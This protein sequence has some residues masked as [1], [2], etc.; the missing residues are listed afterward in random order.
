MT[1]GDGVIDPVLVIRAIRRHRAHLAVDLVKQGAELGGIV[2][3]LGCQRRGDDFAGLGI[4]AK[5]QLSP[6]FAPLCAVLL[7][8]PFAWP[9]QLQPGAVDQ[10]LQRPRPRPGGRRHPQRRGPPAQGG[11]VGHRQ[12]QPHQRQERAD[13][14]L[15]L[16]QR[17]AEHRAQR[18]GG[19]NRQGRI[20]RLPARRGPRCSPP[21]LDRLLSEPDRQ[22]PAPAQPSFVTL[23]YGGERDRSR[24]A[25]LLF[26]ATRTD[27]G[28]P[29]LSIRLS[30]LTAIWVSTCWAGP[31]W[32]RK[33]SPITRLYRLMAASALAL[34]L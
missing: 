16:A 29:R 6:G 1:L 8:Q 23:V 13:Q 30:A 15:G 4:D 34:W 11:V 18:Q 33:V 31:A 14:P 2:H 5:V 12:V 19:L 32:E 24:P 27:S 9:A 26:Q 17:Q 10:Q 20:A 25:F 7:D 21:R 22:G 28:R 3:L